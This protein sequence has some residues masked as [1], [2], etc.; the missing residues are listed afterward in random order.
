MPRLY[1]ANTSRQ[2]WMFNFRDKDVAAFVIQVSSGQQT[3]VDHI[4]AEHMDKVITQMKRYGAIHR[5]ELSRHTEKFEGLVYSL[6]K[7]IS[8]D[9]FHYGH[10][11]V[12][13]QAESRSVV[14]ATKAALASDMVINPRHRERRTLNTQ[15]EFEEETPMRGQKKKTMKITVDANA[16]RSDNI[17][18]Q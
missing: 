17:P 11:E 2:D 13:D 1:V 9:Q 10:D 14:E 12:M 8:V 15:A 5:S 6:D 7:P 3:Q 18:L 16:G 4:K